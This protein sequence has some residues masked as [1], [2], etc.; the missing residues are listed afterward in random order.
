MDYLLSVLSLNARNASQQHFIHFDFFRLQLVKSI[1]TISES[2]CAAMESEIP[3]NSHMNERWYILK[4]EIS[5]QVTLIVIWKI[6]DLE[7]ITITSFVSIPIERE[8]Q[9]KFLMLKINYLCL[10]HPHLSVPKI[11]GCPSMVL[12]WFSSR[13]SEINE[14]IFKSDSVSNN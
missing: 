9:S 4:R 10:K 1:L 14:C 8:I 2:L 6:L 11:S 3:F 7:F 12:S 5:W 13:K